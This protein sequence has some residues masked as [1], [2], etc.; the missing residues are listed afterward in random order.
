MFNPLYKLIKI[1]KHVRTLELKK[2]FVSANEA[3]RGAYQLALKQ[4]PPEMQH[5]LSTN[6]SLRKCGD[7]LITGSNS[8]QKYQSIRKL[9]RL[10]H[11]DH[12]FSRPLKSKRQLISKKSC[13]IHGISGACACFVGGNKARNRSET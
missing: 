12:N 8:E 4:L 2:K 10:W 6:A 5:V 13:H 3:L 11:L 7:A 1:D 9:T